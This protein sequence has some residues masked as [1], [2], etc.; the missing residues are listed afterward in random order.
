MAIIRAF[1]H[2]RNF[3]RVLLKTNIH[4]KKHNLPS[5][6]SR[7]YIFSLLLAVPKDQAIMMAVHYLRTQQV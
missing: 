5:P 2:T 3:R 6:N 7:I 4:F 1:K